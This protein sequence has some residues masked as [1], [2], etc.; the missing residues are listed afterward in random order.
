[1]SRE[2][3]YE[4]ALAGNLPLP[5]ALVRRNGESVRS[6]LEWQQLRRQE[7][8]ADFAR[9]LYGKIPAR[10]QAIRR[11]ILSC[12]E[13]AIE[14]T[15]IRQEIRLH[16]ENNGRHHE[17]DLLFYRPRS[18]AGPVPAVVGLN[19]KGNAA[20]T[21]ESGIRAVRPE[22]QPGEQAARW[23]IPML[24]ANG[25]AVATAYRGDLFPDRADGRA[26]S[27]YR[28]WHEPAELTEANRQLTAISAWAFGCILLKEQLLGDP[29]VDPQRIWVHG[30]SRLGK[31]ALWAAANDPGF[32]GAVS[33]DSGCCGAALSRRNFGE[34]IEAIP[35][36]FPWWFPA[37]LDRYAGN[38]EKLPFDQ[39]AL[40]ALL[41]PRPV[42]VASATEDRWAD[43]RGEFLA[44]KA[45]GEV[46]QLFGGN[47]LGDSEFPAPEQP[48]F[49]Q[50]VG[51]YLRTGVHDVTAVDWQLVLRF[52]KRSYE[53]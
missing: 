29:A 8:L 36:Q 1:M 51:Y 16:L 4:E 2:P 20:C 31:T 27:V 26:D 43:P 39:H 14:G 6:A 53:L 40:L 10:P 28:L 41:A 25:F 5:S 15:A 49:G 50:G 34:S 9:I 23:Q 7:L 44:A 52:I 21:A 30:H 19:F 32:A 37:E 11:E 35:R 45:A 42:L 17:I 48:I 24:I 22:G 47:G 33:N 3:N 12:D 18:A 46:Y 38:E 13:S